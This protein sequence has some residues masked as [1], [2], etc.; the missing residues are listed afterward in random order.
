MDGVSAIALIVIV[1][2]TIERIVTGL[3]FGLSFLGPWRRAFPDPATFA[4]QAWRTEAERK[5]KIVRFVFASLLGIGM[6]A[7]YGDV[8]L[9]KAMLNRDINWFLD[10][11]VTGLALVAGADRVGAILKMPGA[12]GVER[13]SPEPI[14]ITGKLILEDRAERKMES[15][16]GQLEG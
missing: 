9:L 6:L 10:T 15:P 4:D 14:E 7:W 2:F 8:R 16:T 13:R 1:S 5:E 3:L 11:L 12:P